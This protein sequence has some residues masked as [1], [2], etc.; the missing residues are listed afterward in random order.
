[1]KN[2]VLITQSS[3]RR[4]RIQKF[5]AIAARNA[6]ARRTTLRGF[7]KTFRFTSTAAVK[8]YLS[9]DRLQCLLCGHWFR[10]FGKH[11]QLIHATSAREYKLRF[12]IPLSYGMVGDESHAGYVAGGILSSGKHLPDRFSGKIDY[13]KRAPQPDYTLRELG[14][15]TTIRN[16][17]SGENKP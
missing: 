14:Q 3:R 9:G 17:R 8:E 10:A 15:R 16:L 2:P 6:L 12:N 11:F 5:G 4:G 1:M 13:T 7:P